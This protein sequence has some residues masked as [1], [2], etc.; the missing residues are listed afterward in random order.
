MAPAANTVLEDETDQPQKPLSPEDQLEVIAK[1][2]NHDIDSLEFAI[3]MDTSDPLKDFRK[4][5][6]YPKRKEMPTSAKHL[7]ATEGDEECLYFAGNSLGLKPKKADEYVM[8]QMKKWGHMGVKTHFNGHLAAAFCD[9][10]GKV[11]TAEVVGA[12][13][14]EVVIMNGL[15]VNLHFMLQAF[16]RP[17]SKRYKIMFEEHAFPSDRYAFQSLVSLHGYDPND[18]L[19]IVGPR[20]GEDNIRH[21]D[22]L[23]KIEKHGD[24][25]AVVLFS[26]IQYYTGQLFDMPGITAAA[27][28]KGCVVGWDLAH[29]IGNVELKLHDWDMDFAVWCTYKY[30]NSGAGGI[31]GAFLHDRF[32]DN[33]PQ[34]LTGWWANRASTRMDMREEIDFARGADSFRVSNPPPF[35]AAP[36]YASLEIFHEAGMNRI[37][38]KQLLL[39]GFL[40]CLIKKHFGGLQAAQSRDQIKIITPQDTS[41]RGSQ[42]SLRFYDDIKDIHKTLD[43]LGVVCD[44]RD[45]VMRVAPAPLYNSFMDVWKLVQILQKV[46]KND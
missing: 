33:P 42:L 35:L 38:A 5:F 24:E 45:N 18:A 41:Q 12:M 10:P 20:K 9:Q 19:V 3:Y 17:T 28:Q 7:T 2:I 43:C 36:N 40:E 37:V 15:T 29:A 32:A 14:H 21:E 30:L 39:T 8:E 23:D 44:L 6:A 1:K 25:V 34:H 13:V 22:I 31:G 27:K 4:K 16:Y 11:W 26:G 46:L